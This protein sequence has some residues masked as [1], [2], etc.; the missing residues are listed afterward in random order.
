VP[1]TGIP[2][3]GELVCL[4]VDSSGVPVPGNSFTGST[5]GGGQCPVAATS[6]LGFDA[7]N[8]DNVL[9]LGTGVTDTCSTGA[10]Y[11][12]CP[13]GV[14]P[15]RIQGCWSQSQ[16]TFACAAP[17]ATTPIPTST[18]TPT[19]VNP[20]PTQTAAPLAD[21]GLFSAYVPAS[22]VVYPYLSVDSANGVDTV[23]QLTNSSVGAVSVHCFYE[24]T[25]AHCSN[26][27]AVFCISSDT[28]AGGTCVPGWT[29]NDFTIGLTPGQPTSW[30]VSQGLQ[31]IGFVPPVSE[32]PFTGLLRCI[33]VDPSG[34]PFGNNALTGE[35]TIEQFITNTQLAVAK[36]SAVGIPA[37]TTGN[38]DNV[39]ML[40]GLDGEY[41]GCPAV[42]SLNFFFDGAVDPVLPG[43]T[44]TTTLVLAPCSVN[45]AVGQPSSVTEKY[46]IFNEFEQQFTVG[47][48]AFRAQMVSPLSDIS[49]VFTFGVAGTLTG[50]VRFSSEGDGDVLGVAIE[51]HQSTTASQAAGINLNVQGTRDL[52]DTVVLPGP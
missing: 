20:P 25:T 18:P 1:G 42:T 29:V 8:S 47:N 36:Y 52:S 30:R 26:Q 35:A 23:V 17:T 7:N 9:C 41:A 14:D 39:L 24:D 16:F 34:I 33:V 12:N 21:A 43:R 38:G 10:E 6:I 19:P 11:D 15:A 32:D 28:C 50:Q 13:A 2:F 45:Y 4:E 46:V 51:V 3:S 48:G 31:S 37:V 44:L 22:M 5:S 27:P 40:G 49:R